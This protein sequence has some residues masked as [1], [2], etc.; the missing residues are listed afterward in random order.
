[1]SDPALNGAPL[2]HP[3]PWE[4]WEAAAASHSKVAAHTTE[5]LF[6]THDE[7]RDLGTLEGD[8]LIDGFD[9]TWFGSRCLAG[10]DTGN[11]VWPAAVVLKVWRR[12]GVFRTLPVEDDRRWSGLNEKAHAKIRRFIQWQ[13]QRVAEL[14]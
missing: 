2:H 5:E 4:H 14:S 10:D 6:R 1:M 3:S 9:I 12:T 13:E 11:A 8:I 7:G